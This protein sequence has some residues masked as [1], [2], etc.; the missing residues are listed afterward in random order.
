[1]TDTDLIEKLARAFHDLQKHSPVQMNPHKVAEVCLAAIRAE[2]VIV[3]N[4]LFGR[5]VTEL[6]LGARTELCDELYECDR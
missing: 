4:D 5:V 6:D 2:H 1:M 3:P